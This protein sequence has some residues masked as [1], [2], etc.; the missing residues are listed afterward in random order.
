M[1]C[2]VDLEKEKYSN[3]GSAKIQ[4]GESELEMKSSLPH[5]FNLQ[6]EEI[7]PENFALS[8]ITEMRNEKKV[9]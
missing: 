8:H 3:K 1:N 2:L 7:N 5:T 4:E 6:Q 9:V